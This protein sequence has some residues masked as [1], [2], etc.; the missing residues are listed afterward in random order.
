VNLPKMA[1]TGATASDGN[2]ACG[3]AA[4]DALAALVEGRT[5]SRSTAT[6]AAE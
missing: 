3:A 4:P 1:Q 6:S 5:A 2:W